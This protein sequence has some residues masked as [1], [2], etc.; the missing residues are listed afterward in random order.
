MLVQA[1]IIG[2]RKIRVSASLARL[3][4]SL[5]LRAWTWARP[6][7]TWAFCVEVIVEA[8]KVDRHDG[9]WKGG[10]GRQGDAKCNRAVTEPPYH[11]PFADVRSRLWVQTDSRG[12]FLSPPAV[13][14]RSRGCAQVLLVSANSMP[15]TPV[16]GALVARSFAPLCAAKIPPTPR[17][18]PRSKVPRPKRAREN[19]RFNWCCS[20]LPDAW[21]CKC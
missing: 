14:S 13:E 15:R 6:G 7:L 3:A 1:R 2:S 12:S 5:L 10:A 11:P 17:R 20:V 4:P 21:V 8:A 19:S 16:R 9:S 18:S